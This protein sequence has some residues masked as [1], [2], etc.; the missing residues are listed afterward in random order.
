MKAGESIWQFEMD[1]SKRSD[2]LYPEGFYGT[3]K[4]IMTYRHHVV[5]RGKWFPWE[6]KKFGSMNI[7]CDFTKRPIMSAKEAFI[8]RRNKLTASLFR[9]IPYTIRK[10]IGGPIAELPDI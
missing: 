1:G 7:G 10:K 3:W 4:D 8:W 5:E 6:A 2:Q 9:L